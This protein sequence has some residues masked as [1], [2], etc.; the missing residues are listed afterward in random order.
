MKYAIIYSMIVQQIY[1][2][3]C[4]FTKFRNNIYTFLINNVIIIMFYTISMFNFYL[5]SKHS[6]TCVV[7]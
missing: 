5:N 7:V 3:L 6:S 2:I 1:K 4:L